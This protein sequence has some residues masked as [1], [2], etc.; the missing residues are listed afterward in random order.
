MSGKR[1]LALGIAFVLLIFS[2][3]IDVLTSMAFGSWEKEFF[4]TSED[5]FSEKVLE[6]GASQNKIVVL[7]IN[8]VITDTSD[9]SSIFE[10]PGYNHRRFLRMLE[11][12]EESPHVKGLI[13]RVNSPG[14]GVVESAEIHKR[15]IEIKKNTNKPIYISMGSMAA[16]G[17]YYIAT[18]A[19]KIFASPETI[20]G[21]LGVIMQGIN[22]GEFAERLGIRFETIKSGPHKDIMSQTR[23]M[24]EKEREIIQSLIDNSYEQFVSVI[25]E[26]RKLSKETVR[27]I[28]DGRIYDG[29]Q[30]KK[31]GL[32]DSFG[33]YDDVVETM[34]KD[35]N[36][37]TASVITFQEQFGFN[38]FFTMAARKV[39][40]G[41]NDLL[42]LSKLLGQPNS[43]KLMYLYSR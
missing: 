14:G 21:S 6:E 18:A 24:T 39:G 36:M 28:A 35:L 2:I 40:E 16:S 32:I 1:W 11:K 7:D 37:E 22:Y 5:E 8:G 34:K 15:L 23:P 17:G 27:D 26:G 29:R 42:G 10:S 38:S 12:A 25:S 33:Y 9:V 30:A 3:G 4:Q 13:I 43:P 31:L 20:T 41:N 19:D